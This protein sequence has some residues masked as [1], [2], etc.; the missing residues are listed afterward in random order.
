MGGGKGEEYFENLTIYNIN[1][2]SSYLD[3]VAYIPRFYSILFTLQYL[4]ALIKQ[5]YCI[6]TFCEFNRL[7]VVFLI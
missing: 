7:W 6:S 5:F 4:L 1:H 3:Y 2:L